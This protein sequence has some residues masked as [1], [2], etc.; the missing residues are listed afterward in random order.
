MRGPAIIFFLLSF[1]SLQNRLSGWKTIPQQL[2]SIGALFTPSR[3]KQ[4]SAAT[5]K[6]VSTDDSAEI[7]QSV[8]LVDSMNSVDQVR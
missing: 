1:C 7:T 5:K 4:E 8:M 6:E 3:S 2:R